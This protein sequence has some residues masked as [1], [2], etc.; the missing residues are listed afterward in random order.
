MCDPGLTNMIGRDQF[1]KSLAL[2]AL[3]QL[4]KPLEDKVLLNYTDKGKF[5]VVVLYNIYL[6]RFPVY[7]VLYSHEL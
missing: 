3:A 7:I 2:T 5:A 6:K 4:G 1:Y